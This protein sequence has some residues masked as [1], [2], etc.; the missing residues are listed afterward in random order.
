M[1]NVLVVIGVGGSFLGAKAIQDA[2]TPYFGNCADGIE[3]IYVGQNMSSAY[4]S[5][6][7]NS[8]EHKEVYVMELL[9]QNYI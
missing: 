2:L 1:A 7:L 4:I 8:L 3:V 9:K 6:L 5:Q